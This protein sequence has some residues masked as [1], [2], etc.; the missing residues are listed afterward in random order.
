[1][2][3]HLKSSIY[4]NSTVNNHSHIDFN[5]A[6]CLRSS[7]KTLLTHKDNTLQSRIQTFSSPLVVRD[8]L[9]VT[10]RVFVFCW[11]LKERKTMKIYLKNSYLSLKVSTRVLYR[12]LDCSTYLT[13]LYKLLLVTL[14]PDASGC[15]R[16]L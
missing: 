6:P 3:T 12:C 5:R 10:S 2:G 11:E 9:L 7:L 16:R 14:S 1:M 15:L 8:E 4:Y 13:V